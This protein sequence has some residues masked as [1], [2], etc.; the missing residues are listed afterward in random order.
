VTSLNKFISTLIKGAISLGLIALFFYQVDWQDIL[1]TAKTAQAAYLALAVLMFVLSNFLGAIQWHAL[2]Q[3]QK[4]DLPFKQVLALYFV[5][6]FFNNFMVGN[7][8]GDAVRI[9]DL[10]RLTGRGI[11]GFAATFLDRFIGLFVLSSFSVIAFAFSPQL[12]QSA[13]VLPILS[14]GGG[15]CAVLCFGFSGRLSDLVVQLCHRLLPSKVA[16]FVSDIRDCFQIYRRAYAVLVRVG[17]LACGV[18][19]SRVGVYFTVGLAL[20]QSVAFVHYLT[21][22]PL[23]AIVA[24]VPIS[25][26]G[27]GVRENMGALL[28]GQVGM[29]APVALTLMFFG[30][31]TGIVASLMGGIMF[32]LRKTSH[33]HREEAS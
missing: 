1:A 19:L 26:G 17:L 6:V 13:L 20:G 10:K 32:V 29:A 8:G 25:F 3:L 23:I 14:L 24:A 12:W 11:S 27:I 31:L 5:G 4:I 9:Y 33:P 16:G 7:V 21:F 18:Q 2:L 15:L 28:F 22:I 30:Y